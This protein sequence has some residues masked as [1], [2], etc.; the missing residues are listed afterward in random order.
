MLNLSS[1]LAFGA[2]YDTNDPEERKQW[3]TKH[4]FDQ[5]QDR[6]FKA[7]WV[8]RVVEDPGKECLHLPNY[9]YAD[10]T[11]HLG[12]HGN[13]KDLIA[14]VTNKVGQVVTLFS[15]PLV[16][17]LQLFQQHYND[18]DLFALLKVKKP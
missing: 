18:L 12:V 15:D 16:S 17:R 13:G 7:K 5:F 2:K 4:G 6:K 8:Q 14:V 1:K 9:K 11:V 3:Y 10:E